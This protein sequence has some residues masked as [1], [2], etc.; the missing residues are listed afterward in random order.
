[1]EQGDGGLTEKIYCYSIFEKT[2]LQI[3]VLLCTMCLS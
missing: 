3:M 2:F 1:V